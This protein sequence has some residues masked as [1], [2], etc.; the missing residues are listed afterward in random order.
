V[1]RD[2]FIKQWRE[3]VFSGLPLAD[4][5]ETVQ[6]RVQG[7]TEDLLLNL[8]SAFELDEDEDFRAMAWYL[9]YLMGYAAANDGAKPDKPENGASIQD[10]S[11]LIHEAIVSAAMEG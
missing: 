10:M 7:L 4:H 9:A 6:I 1:K 5:P 8:G 2:E 3:G 11:E